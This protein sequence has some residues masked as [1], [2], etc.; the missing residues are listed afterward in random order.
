[1]KCY[2]KALME[3]EISGYQFSSAP[4]MGKKLTCV[5]RDKMMVVH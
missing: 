2:K 1:M 4:L 3:K 5:K